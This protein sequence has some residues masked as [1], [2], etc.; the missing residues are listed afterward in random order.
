MGEKN[1]IKRIYQIIYI[2]FLAA[3]MAIILDNAILIPIVYPVFVALVV[4]TIIVADLIRLFRKHKLIYVLI[5][6]TATVAV[7]VCFIPGVLGTIHNTVSYAING[8]YERFADK[9]LYNMLITVV[10]ALSAALLSYLICLICYVRVSVPIVLIVMCIICRINGC[11]ISQ[12][13]LAAVLFTF[14][15]SSAEIISFISK[16]NRYN[17]AIFMTPVFL[18]FCIIV[19]V[20]PITDKPLEWKRTKKVIDIVENRVEKLYTN[21]L[22]ILN[23]DD[24]SDASTISGYSDSDEM[25]MCDSVSRNDTIQLSITGNPVKPNMYLTGTCYNIFNDN[26]WSCSYTNPKYPEMAIELYESVGA[27]LDSDVEPCN[28]PQFIKLRDIKIQNENIKTKTVFSIMPTIHSIEKPKIVE[29]NGSQRFE[30]V[31]K[32]GYKYNISHV[33]IDYSSPYYKYIC[34]HADDE[35]YNITSSENIEYRANYLL[36]MELDTYSIE[37]EKMNSYLSKRTDYINENYMSI[38]ASVT[39]RVY[40][41]AASITKDEKSIYDKAKAIESY[42]RANY[43]YSKNPKK[44]D[45]HKYIDS[46]LFD[47]KEGFCMHFA[48]SMAI[49]ARCVGIPSRIVKGYSVHYNGSPDKSVIHYVSGSAAHAWAEVYIYGVGWMRCETTPHY[50]ESANVPWNDISDKENEYILENGKSYP[51]KLKEQDALQDSIDNKTK[52]MKAKASPGVPDSAAQKQDI[53]RQSKNVNRNKRTIC[54][55][56][57]LLIVVISIS[58]TVIFVIKCSKRRVYIAA[59][60]GRKC[61]MLLDSIL[62]VLKKKGIVLDSKCTLLEFAE[63]NKAIFAENYDP[64]ILLINDYQ[65]Y[66]FGGKTI[67]SESVY[68]AEKLVKGISNLAVLKKS[69]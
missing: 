3:A 9:E 43:K 14:M 36:G 54:F 20:I 60:N 32:K 50:A 39:K 29:N 68:K 25:Q 11:D 55:V 51:K 2:S 66:R 4:I 16:K 67:S 47:T 31:H 21:A 41:L 42:I 26:K 45:E 1:L 33:N 57:L 52:D 62:D 34:E 35:V 24:H 58:L 28:Y 30:E 5:G 15:I 23:I 22:H 46:F 61:R 17:I 8:C 37:S 64:F 38:P 53:L 44:A 12:Y 59:C 65:G 63:H 6:L 7:Y 49:M 10:M 27:I 48:S 40:N 19:A 56:F 69:D 13:A 18:V